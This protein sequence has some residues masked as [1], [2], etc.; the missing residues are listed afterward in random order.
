[1]SHTELQRC[2]TGGLELQGIHAAGAMTIGQELVA[3]LDQGSDTVLGRIMTRSS[4]T[5]APHNDTVQANGHVV[6]AANTARKRGRHPDNQY[7]IAASGSIEASKQAAQR[8]SKRLSLSNPDAR[9]CHAAATKDPAP[10]IKQN[11]SSSCYLND[12]HYEENDEG[13]AHADVATIAQVAHEMKVLLQQ[14]QRQAGPF[15]SGFIH[16]SKS[17]SSG[18]QPR[19]KTAHSLEQYTPP[20]QASVKALQAERDGCQQVIQVLKQ[21]QEAMLSERGDLRARCQQ[22]QKEVNH[23]HS[24]KGSLS[25]GVSRLV[26]QAR[27]VA[28]TV[29]MQ[30]R[31]QLEEMTQQA[32]SKVGPAA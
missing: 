7:N 12:R 1:M 27:Q 22:L 17:Y 29:R 21:Q 24:E 3:T 13:D 8:S 4:K 14:L 26:E 32:Q 18:P 30:C 31:A 15:A 20:G 11:P 16:M 5:A 28:A 6:Q 25:E 2:S 9:D 23:L 19:S 10:I